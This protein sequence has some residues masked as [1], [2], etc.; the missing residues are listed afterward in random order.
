MVEPTSGGSVRLRVENDIPTGNVGFDVNVGTLGDID[1]ISIDAKGIESGEEEGPFL[2]VG[3]YFD[4]EGTGDYFEWGRVHG[5]SEAFTNFGDDGE[6]LHAIPIGT[7]IT[8]SFEWDV[9]IVPAESAPPDAEQKGWVV[10]DE[11]FGFAMA[12]RPAGVTLDDYRDGEVTIEYDDEDNE[13]D[14]I[15]LNT[16]ED[17]DVALAINCMGTGDGNT[18]EMIVHDFSIK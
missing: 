11:F 2:W 7:G 14:E 10:D 18:E 17:T 12:P 9:L 4:K 3:V 6:C 16:D 1:E 15:E 5:N 13:D 8:C